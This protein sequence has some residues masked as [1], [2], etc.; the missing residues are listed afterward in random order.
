MKRLSFALVLFVVSSNIFAQTSIQ[1]NARRDD[2]PQQSSPVNEIG[3]A[4]YPNAAYLPEA[5][6]RLLN[7][8]A[9]TWLLAR[10]YHT[11]DS[12]NDVAK[13][14]KQQSQK[15]SKPAEGNALVK[16]LL[17][18]NWKISKGLVRFASTVF[19][20]GS[21]LR[22]PAS[23]EKAETTF[24]VIVLDDS[25]VRIHLMSPHPSS[26]NNNRLASGTLI[27]V[28]K[29][30]LTQPADSATNQTG[31][32]PEKV[33]SGR[34]VTKRARVK[35]KPEPESGRTGIYGVVVLRAVLSSSGK[36]TNIR[37]MSGLPGGLTEAAIKAAQ[38]IK[39]EPAIKDGHYV[40]TYVQLEYN[41]LP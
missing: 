16:S 11:D 24:G 26:A 5:T 39:F 36:V 7:V 22:T 30:R 6:E 21:E 33:Y 9:S 40:S 41:F 19:G 20:V 10:V 37:V 14:F 31:A 23:A 32:E 29:E 18:N 15:L 13:Y 12:I 8:K 34:E 2:L 1:P 38:E 3:I 27:L 17:R 35:S 25:I 4:Q 28:I